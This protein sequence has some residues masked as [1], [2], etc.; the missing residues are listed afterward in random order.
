MKFLV[1]LFIVFLLI[2]CQAQPQYYQEKIYS[3]KEVAKLY[4]AEGRYAEALRELELAKE[5]LLRPQF[6][7]NIENLHNLAPEERR[8]ICDPEV[9]NLLG[10]VYLAKRDFQKA[11]N[12][13]Q[14][15]LQLDP[16]YSEAYTNLGALRMK[17]ERYQ[18]A[19]FYFEKAISNPLYTDSYIALANMGWSYYKLKDKEKALSVLSQAIKENPRASKPLI[20]TALFI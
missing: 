2:S 20:Y 12:Y 1:F 9:Y 8:K 5:T 4:I 11:E 6:C 14:S 18:E 3:H 16:Q 19:I 17:Q 10:I 7:A 13:F 15:S